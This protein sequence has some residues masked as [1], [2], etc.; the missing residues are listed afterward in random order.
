MFHLH[1]RTWSN[2]TFVDQSIDTYDYSPDNLELVLLEDASLVAALDAATPA[3]GMR[4]LRRFV[5]LRS[6][7]L[8]L[9]A[10]TE[11]DE[12]QET[13]EGTAQW[14]QWRSVG[15]TEPMYGGP[16]IA[17]SLADPGGVSGDPRLYLA[18]SRYY[19]TGATIMELLDRNGLEWLEPIEG[20]ASPAEVLRD[21]LTVDPADHEALIEE[22][23]QI[24]NSDKQLTELAQRWSDAAMSLDA[25]S[26]RGVQ[27]V[28][29]Q[30][31]PRRG[32]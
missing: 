20:G 2:R 25:V 32:R 7:R 30:T 24:H 13:T 28:E 21:A 5:A 14:V 19:L 12:Q 31:G 26:I 17:T 29:S 3:D 23:Q 6:T 16:D 8:A 18:F 9:S 27:F 4:A 11:L 15:R 22:A 10:S 1:Q